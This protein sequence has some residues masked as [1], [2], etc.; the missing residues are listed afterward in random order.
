MVTGPKVHRANTTTASI[1]TFF[2]DD[3]VHMALIVADD[4]R[5]VTTIERPDLAGVNSES[6]LAAASGTLVDRTIGPDDPIETALT[7]LRHGNRRR[8]AVVGEAGE[9]LGLLCLKRD[10]SGYCSDENVREREAERS[11]GAHEAPAWQSSGHRT[12]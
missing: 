6:V 3:H 1:V 4:G 5:L 10:S 9:L 7:I 12:S 8:L 2:Q 11:T